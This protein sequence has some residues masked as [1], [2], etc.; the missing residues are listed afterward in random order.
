M[1][2]TAQGRKMLRRAATRGVGDGW[3]HLGLSFA[4]VP[5]LLFPRP[6]PSIFR[7]PVFFFAVCDAEDCCVVSEETANHSLVTRAQGNAADVNQ[8]RAAKMFRKASKGGDARAMVNLGWMH[9]QGHSSTLLS[10]AAGV[11]VRL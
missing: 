10:N 5:A 6:R 3:Y 2:D 1:Q 7:I 11:A 8:T 4:Q 9:A